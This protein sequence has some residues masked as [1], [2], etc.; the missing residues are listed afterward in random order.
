MTHEFPTIQSG[1]EDIEVLSLLGAGGSKTVLEVSVGG[2]KRA[3]AI[4]NTVDVED[5]RLLKWRCALTEPGHTAFL[6]NNGLLVS[7]YCEV[8]ELLVDG[9]ATDALIMTPFSE[10]PF[11]IYDGK[12]GG[13]TWEHG[14]LS[15]IENYMDLRPAISG[16][17]KDI[18]RLAELGIALKNDSI[19]FAFMPGGEM[20]LFL[21]DL[22]G[23]STTD[24]PEGLER[25]YAQ[26]VVNKVDNII[27]FEQGRRFGQQGYDLR[28]HQKLASVLISQ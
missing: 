16:V 10:L 20:R 21:F 3:L 24:T 22:A 23:M 25:A 9:E 7:P 1:D 28:E 12:D 14:P 6:R 27:D 8:R 15:H 13:K 5:V 4:P 19:S 18:K 11:E 26:A 17:S 2:M